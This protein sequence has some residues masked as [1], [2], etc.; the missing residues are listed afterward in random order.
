[1]SVNM[2]YSLEGHKTAIQQIDAMKSTVIQKEEK[3]SK[4]N[5]KKLSSDKRQEDK[6]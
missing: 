5:E 6:D 4:V 1:M 3:D 2:Y